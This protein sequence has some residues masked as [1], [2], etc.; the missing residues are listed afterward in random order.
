M[1]GVVVRVVGGDAAGPGSASE[2][3]IRRVGVRRPLA[4]GVEFIRH[5]TRRFVV[6]PAGRVALLRGVRDNA[7][8]HRDI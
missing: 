8:Y 4:I 7:P 1:P 3:A 6:E 5:T 2:L